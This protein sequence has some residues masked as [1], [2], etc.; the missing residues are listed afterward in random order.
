[1]TRA[2]HNVGATY[3]QGFIASGNVIFDID[4][5]VDDELIIEIEQSFYDTCGFDTPAVIRTAAEVRSVSEYRP[6]REQ[7][8]EL[9]EG[10]WFV[11]FLKLTPSPEVVR[12]I[13]ARSTATDQLTIHDKE[14]YWLPIDGEFNSD[15]SIPEVER[16]V[17]TMTMRVINTVDR[18]VDRFLV[19]D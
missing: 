11:G 12:Q 3:A 16:L 8:M 1:M 17:G 6:F 4:R 14:L 9:S 7:D 5:L 18:I 15:I 10:T 13:A 2:L 19:G